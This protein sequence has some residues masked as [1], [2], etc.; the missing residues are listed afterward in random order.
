M[1]QLQPKKIEI[2]PQ[3]TLELDPNPGF[4]LKFTNLRKT[5]YPTN[6]PAESDYFKFKIGD[7]ITKYNAQT[8][9]YE[10]VAINRQPLVESQAK[11]WDAKL[12]RYSS[13]YGSA[14]TPRSTDQIASN[15]LAE[16]R[17]NGNFGICQI[18]IK[19][20]LRGDKEVVKGKLI[21][22]LEMDHVKAINHRS[23]GKVD[24]RDIIKNRDYAINRWGKYVNAYQNKLDRE[25]L[26][27]S[28]VVRLYQSKLTPI[29]VATPVEEAA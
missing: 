4:K 18:T 10:V 24:L 26:L 2:E 9:I 28:A 22:F 23:F 15:L 5:A 20:I 25:L 29:V 16:Y 3:T 14:S 12:L 27:K 21:R 17:K 11:G 1:R 8:P 7:Y 6:T 13:G 19:P